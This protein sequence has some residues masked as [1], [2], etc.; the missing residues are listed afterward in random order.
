MMMVMLI[1]LVA[2]AA[3]AMS[4]HS[5]QTEL[6]AAGHNRQ[7]I[8]TQ[9]VSEAAMMTTI[10]WLDQ[11]A[12]NN[13]LGPLIIESDAVPMPEMFH[14]ALPEY[15]SADMRQHAMHTDADHQAKIR[16]DFET[17]PMGGPQLPTA[18]VS[19]PV[20]DPIGS[21]GPQQAYEPQ[22]RWYAHIN[23]CQDAPLGMIAGDHAAGIRSEDRPAPKFFCVITAFG[24][25]VLSGY[26]NL[27]PVTAPG[28][29]G[30]NWNVQ[31]NVY[32]SSK[33]AAAHDS[34]AMILTK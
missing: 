7:A 30:H 8:Q 19:A 17:S 27:S 21:F 23:E 1:L 31:G 13:V 9:Y 12:Y 25:T 18:G 6:R 10:A 11:L 15:S 2:T 24:R 34:R 14:F 29:D 33:F 5:V 20:P 16:Q 28:R 4:V 26:D 22:A 32:Q 3:A